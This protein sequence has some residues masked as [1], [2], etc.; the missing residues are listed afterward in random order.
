[1]G[2]RSFLHSIDSCKTRR[3]GWVRW[4]Q[5][6][7]KNYPVSAYPKST[8]TLLHYIVCATTLCVPLTC[9][10]MVQ[11]LPYFQNDR[12]YHMQPT[13]DFEFERVDCELCVPLTCLKVVQLFLY[14]SND[15]LYHEPFAIEFEFDPYHV[16]VLWCLCMNLACAS[17]GIFLFSPTICETSLTQ[18]T[19]HNGKSQVVNTFYLHQY[20]MHALC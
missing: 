6:Q 9:L 19:T 17:L 5:F 7:F 15:F 13:T 3:F 16:N 8:S 18:K 20:Y 14:F 11:L 10:K 2:K 12:L 1:M 4:R